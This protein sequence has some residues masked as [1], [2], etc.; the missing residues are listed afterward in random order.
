MPILNSKRSNYFHAKFIKSFYCN[1][2]S[3]IGS[4]EI[5]LMALFTDCKVIIV[6]N[7]IIVQ[8]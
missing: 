3:E 7:N 2:S 6:D 4:K 1:D 8:L 5:V